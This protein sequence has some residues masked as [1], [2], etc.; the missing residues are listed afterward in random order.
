MIRT[1]VM[2][3]SHFLQRYAAHF[4]THVKNRTC[5]IEVHSS[6]WCPRNT[7]S[8]RKDIAKE[9]NGKV[10]DAYATLSNAVPELKR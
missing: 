1:Q 3:S 10:K 9:M 6:G 2:N 7:D 4:F 5:N 8:I